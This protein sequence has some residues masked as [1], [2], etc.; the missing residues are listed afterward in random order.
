MS[1]Y[2]LTYAKLKIS[3]EAYMEIRGKLENAGYEHV[4]RDKNGVNEVMVLGEIGLVPEKGC[5][6][7]SHH[8]SCDCNGMGGDR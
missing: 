7:P 1:S 8:W 5:T 4:F 6:M 2:S 3:Y